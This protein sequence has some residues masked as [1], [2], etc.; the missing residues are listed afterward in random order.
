MPF[1]PDPSEFQVR[2]RLGAEVGRLRR[3]VARTTMVRHAFRVLTDDKIKTR[4]I[5]FSE[6]KGHTLLELAFGYLLVR[7]EVASVIAGATS[8]EQVKSNTSAACWT[9]TDEE[10]LERLRQI[11]PAYVQIVELR[12]F[13]G[14]TVEEVAD[15]LGELD[16][17]GA[18]LLLDRQ[19]DAR[20]GVHAGV[21]A[22]M[23][24]ALAD[25]GIN[26]Q[27]ITTSEIKISVLVA[28]E[29]GLEALRTVHKVFQL[30]VPPAAQGNASSTAGS[31]SKQDPAAVVRR[32]QGMEDL[33]V[34]DIELDETQASVT[35][36][37]VPDTP[38]VA[39]Q[40]FEQIAAGGIFVDMIVQSIGRENRADISVT[41]K[42]ARDLGTVAFNKIKLVA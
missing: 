21:A 1:P 2:V 14:L 29:Q 33:T 3:E 9:L 6:R 13:V 19:D 7:P 5:A 23:F 34:E 41:V 37:R 31:T 36:A 26:V 17:R 38:G 27:A 39:A 20:V 35:I 32:L 18:G 4:L 24:K 10:M 15:A 12:Y 30:D 40:V 28:R 11:E 22:Q 25:R 42:H 8:E 16:G